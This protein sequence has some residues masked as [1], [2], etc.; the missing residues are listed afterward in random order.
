MK[1]LYI[2]LALG[3]FQADLAVKHEIETHPEFEKEQELLNGR[4]MIRKLHNHG[5]AGSRFEGHM[6]AI[7]RCSGILTLGAI[8]TFIRTLWKPGRRV[9]KLGF[10]FLTGGALSNL[11]D[12]CRRGYVV[13]YVSFRT[14]WKRLNRLVFNLADFFIAIGAVLVGLGETDRP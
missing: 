12:R 7:I 8:L 4:V 3:L 10:A 13:D 5:L 6:P 2:Q 14:P 1:L 9:Q 11:Y